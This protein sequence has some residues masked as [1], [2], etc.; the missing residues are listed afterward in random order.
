MPLRLYIFLHLI[1]EDNTGVEL[2]V[3]TG[4]LLGV[5]LQISLSCRGPVCAGAQ[6]GTSIHIDTGHNHTL[7]NSTAYAAIPFHYS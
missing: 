3:S 1:M 5:C 4:A 6:I 7:S 2:C